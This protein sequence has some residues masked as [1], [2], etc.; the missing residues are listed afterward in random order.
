[1][2]DISWSIYSIILWKVPLYYYSMECVRCSLNIF[3]TILLFYGCLL[4]IIN[5]LNLSM[6]LYGVRCTLNI[7]KKHFIANLIPLFYHSME[8][9]SIS[10]IYVIYGI[11][12][13]WVIC[14]W[15]ISKTIFLFYGSLLYIINL[16]NLSMELYGVRCT[17]NIFKKHFNPNLIPLFY[18]SMEV[19]SISLI[20]GNL[21]NCMARCEELIEYYH[22]IFLLARA[23]NTHSG[24]Y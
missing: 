20:Y 14:T 22:E 24:L 6:E 9:Y 15:N 5:L 10:L 16:W 18:H 19:Y 21:W 12:L 1:M 7:F 17:L 23:L 4:Y 2:W 3:K 11:V 8:V 13:Q